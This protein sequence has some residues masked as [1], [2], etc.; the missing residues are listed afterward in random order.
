MEKTPRAMRAP[1]RYGVVIGF[2]NIE[3]IVARRRRASDHSADNW[4]K[5]K[6]L[7]CL[8]PSII[9]DRTACV[10]YDRLTDSDTDIEKN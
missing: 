7:I 10:A 5:A 3:R 2:T 1:P 8:D 6:K 4:P 9:T